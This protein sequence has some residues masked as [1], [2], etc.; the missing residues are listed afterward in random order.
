MENDSSNLGEYIN[1]YKDL[2][3]Y[4]L[5]NNTLLYKK[6]YY[7]CETCEIKGNNITHNCL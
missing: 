7:T 5:D 2:K 6:C 3:G 1:C 4:Y